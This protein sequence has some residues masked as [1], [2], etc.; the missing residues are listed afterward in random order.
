[1]TGH[2]ITEGGA[3]FLLFLGRILMGIAVH[4]TLVAF[5]SAAF[6]VSGEASVL[7]PVVVLGAVL[8]VFYYSLYTLEGLGCRRPQS[9]QEA[10][11]EAAKQQNHVVETTAPLPVPDQ[12]RSNRLSALGMTSWATPRSF[13]RSFDRRSSEGSEGSSVQVNVT[14]EKT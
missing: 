12:S 13:G 4:F 8:F 14:P 9:E 3:E 2:P 7:V 6:I 11:L 1:M 5:F 10:A